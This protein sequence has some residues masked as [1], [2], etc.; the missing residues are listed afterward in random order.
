[1]PN[2]VVVVIQTDAP[3][4]DLNNTVNQST[5]KLESMN[6]VIN[7]IE[8]RVAGAKSSIISVSTSTAAPTINLSGTGAQ[9]N[10]FQF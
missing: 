6:A 10:N 7:S 1:M 8:K 4:A 2:Y 9:T 3:L 5:K